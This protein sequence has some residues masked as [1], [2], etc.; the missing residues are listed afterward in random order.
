MWK[1]KLNEEKIT[2][3]AT[4][5]LNCTNVREF[6]TLDLRKVT[7]ALNFNRRYTQLSIISLHKTF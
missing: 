1:Y 6:S 4:K 5:S 2:I 3:E 7:A